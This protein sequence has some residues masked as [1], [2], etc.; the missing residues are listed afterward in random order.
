M[1]LSVL[2]CKWKSGDAGGRE[3]LENEEGS[4]GLFIT[5]FGEHALQ[6]EPH[7][8][9]VIVVGKFC[10]IVITGAY[11]RQTVPPNNT[12]LCSQNADPAKLSIC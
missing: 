3:T 7:L 2:T 4:T 6:M 10:P 9:M 11:E 1:K 8:W 5:R 12:R